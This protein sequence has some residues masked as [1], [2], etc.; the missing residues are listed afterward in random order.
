MYTLIP[1]RRSLV[2]ARLHILDATDT[3]SHVSD[4]LR[5]FRELCS[6]HNNFPEQDLL[7]AVHLVYKENSSDDSEPEKEPR[8]TPKIRN[9][10]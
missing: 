4:N 3:E 10:Q 9:V 1:E 5:A 7:D 8:S 6:L 2:L